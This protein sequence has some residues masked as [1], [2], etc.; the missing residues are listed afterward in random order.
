MWQACEVGIP[1]DIEGI[2]HWK[3]ASLRVADQFLV[4]GEVHPFTTFQLDQILA[5]ARDAGLTEREQGAFLVSV[6]ASDMEK[7]GWAGVPQSKR[8][9]LATA[10]AMRMIHPDG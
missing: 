2:A 1:L 10:F 6:I 5:A 9:T 8:L 3:T 4:G 7:R